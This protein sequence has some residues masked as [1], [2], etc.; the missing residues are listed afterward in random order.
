MNRPIR[1]VPEVL[2]ASRRLHLT[3]TSHRKAFGTQVQNLYVRRTAISP[4][5]QPP[6]HQVAL[7]LEVGELSPDRRRFTG[8]W[9]NF[10]QSRR[11]ERRGRRPASR[12]RGR[13]GRGRRAH[14]RRRFFSPLRG[15]CHRRWRKWRRI[16]G[17]EAFTNVT[18]FC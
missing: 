5:L 17:R 7:T 13:D 11:A 2:F 1:G 18:R 8:F 9:G 6:C 3:S 10:H 15:T 14:R 12:Q 4:F 16:R